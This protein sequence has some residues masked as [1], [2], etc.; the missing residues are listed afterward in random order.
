MKS[1]STGEKSVYV[2]FKGFEVMYHVATLLPYSNIDM[3]QL[4]RM[5]S[6]IFLCV[7]VFLTTSSQESGILE[8]IL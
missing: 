7:L 2:K 3:Q 6:I 1:G 4:E 5:S 8:T